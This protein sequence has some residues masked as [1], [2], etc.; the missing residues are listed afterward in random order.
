MKKKVKQNC[1]F[2]TSIRSLTVTSLAQMFWVWFSH[3]PLKGLYKMDKTLKP[4]FFPMKKQRTWE[5]VKA[6]TLYVTIH[7]VSNLDLPARNL[8][9]ICYICRYDWG[10]LIGRSQLW[11]SKLQSGRSLM[12]NAHLRHRR[13]GRWDLYTSKHRS[14]R[15]EFI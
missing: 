2:L 8:I 5:V 1:I 10:D 9:F 7:H 12:N 13:Q 4:S 14:Q 3:W 15:T 6:T 11:S